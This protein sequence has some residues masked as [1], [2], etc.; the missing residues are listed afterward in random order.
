MG[1]TQTDEFRKDAVQIAL[2]SGLTRKQL[3]ALSEQNWL[4]R[5]ERFHS[6]TGWQNAAPSAT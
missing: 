1:R 2:S 3:A 5:V 4:N 6:I